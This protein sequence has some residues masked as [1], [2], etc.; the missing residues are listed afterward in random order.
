MLYRVLTNLGKKDR[1]ITEGSL[2]DPSEFSSEAIDKLLRM[3]KIA[4]VASPPLSVLP[5]W[6]TRAKKLEAL[7]I[8]TIEQLIE[9]KDINKLA[10]DLDSNPV[11]VNSWINE[12]RKKLE[13][14]AKPGG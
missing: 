8:I 5:N 13:A 9:C 12:A 10:E 3:G 1:V 6:K 4:P 11:V 7:G 2:I 14:P